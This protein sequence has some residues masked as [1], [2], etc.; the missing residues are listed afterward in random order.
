M[1]NEKLQPT[2][3]G[4]S[5]VENYTLSILQRHFTNINC[6]FCMSFLR[7]DDLLYQI[8]KNHAKHDNIISLPRIH[9]V[10][11]EYLS[12]IQLSSYDEIE[13]KSVWNEIK[14]FDDKVY[15][16][17]RVKPSFVEKKLNI[18]LMRDDHYICYSF[19]KNK[20]IVFNDYPYR[21]LQLA[22]N[23][24]L[25]AYDGNMLVFKIVD[26]IND[27]VKKKSYHLFC[28]HIKQ[29]LNKASNLKVDIKKLNI[30]Y[31]KE[32][33]IVYKRV[34]QRTALFCSDYTELDSSLLTSV[35]LV[36]N[37]LTKIYIDEIKKR[38]FN[39]QRYIGDVSKVLYLD[40]CVGNFLYSF[41]KSVK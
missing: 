1:Y 7:A 30:G 24:I 29:H 10:A 23:E 17:I 18:S 27:V 41:L 4:L 35:T 16:L 6:L 36:D 38:K 13:I 31:V 39:I 20:N 14:S 5:C 26:D 3:L 2:A 34:L 25:K 11:F 22:D 8:V 15:Y 9:E 21:I 32:F 12:L 28:R 33:L 37:I 19:E 40:R